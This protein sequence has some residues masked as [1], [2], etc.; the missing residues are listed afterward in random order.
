MYFFFI[1]L[2]IKEYKKTIKNEQILFLLYKIYIK[3][4]NI[5][6]LKNTANFIN[7]IALFKINN[8]YNIVFINNITDKNDIIIVIFYFI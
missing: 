5:C 1:N 3:Y 4:S 8:K 7:I 2:N 6:Q